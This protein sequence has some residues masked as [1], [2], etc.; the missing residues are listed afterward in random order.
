MRLLWLS[1]WSVAFL[2]LTACSN[3]MPAVGTHKTQ[4]PMNANAVGAAYPSADPPRYMPVAP[5]F[6]PPQFYRT[7][8]SPSSY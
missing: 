4:M 2:T 3:T 6:N 8:Y 5:A 1:L 7:A